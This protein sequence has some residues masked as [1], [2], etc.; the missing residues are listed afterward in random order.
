MTGCHCTTQM[1]GKTFNIWLHFRVKKSIPDTE[2]VTQRAPFWLRKQ[3]QEEVLS[4]TSPYRTQFPS[5]F[6]SFVGLWYTAMATS[7]VVQ[8]L[9]GVSGALAVAAGA[10]GA[11]GKN[12]HFIIARCMT[13][14]SH[15]CVVNVKS[16][17]LFCKRC[18]IGYR[19]FMS[20]IWP[21]GW[22][23]PVQTAWCRNA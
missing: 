2:T 5:S 21:W 10:Y 3:L 6:T 19:C 9:A 15:D 11:H 7:L 23:S 1:K 4:L 16:S 22:D 18:R 13:N 17:L 8:R 12:P 20:L 14:R